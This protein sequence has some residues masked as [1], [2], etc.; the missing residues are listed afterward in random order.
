MSMRNPVSPHLELDGAGNMV[1]CTIKTEEKTDSCHESPQG[2]P[3]SSDPHSSDLHGVP[4]S[5]RESADPRTLPQESRSPVSNA[6]DSRRSA[7]EPAVS[8]QEKLDFNRNLKE[9]MPT[10]EKL[11][12]SDWKERLLGRNTME[13]KEVKG[14][15]ESLAEKELQLLVMIN[16]L[17]TLRDQLLTAHSEQKNMAAMLFEKQQQQMELA[18]QQ[19]EQASVRGTPPVAPRRRAQA[20]GP[21]KARLAGIFQPPYHCCFP[22]RQIAKQ[23]QQ[24]IQQQ[25]K[26]NLLQQQIQQV[27]MPYVMIPAFPPSH[28]PLPVTSDSQLALPIQPI[29]CKPVEY[30][31]QLLH[32]PPP[33]TLKRPA[34]SGHLQMQESS[35]PLNLTAKPK[36]SELSS[37]SSSPS[38]K[39]SS[40][41]S[42]TP[43]HGVTRDLQSSPPSLPLGFLGEGD[44]ITKALQD[45]RQLLHCHSGATESSLNNPYRKDQM[46]LDSSPMKERMEETCM[47]RLDESMLTCDVDGSR[48]FP[49]SRNNNHIKRPMNA[50]MV[51]AKD[52]RRKI[53]QAFPDMHNSSISK[54]LGSRWKS[55][56]NQEKQPYYEEQARLSRQHLEKYPDY[57]YKPRPKRTCIVEGKRLRVG[58]YKALMR[59][60]RQDTRQGYLIAPQGSQMQ[61]SSSDVLYQR[62]VS[63]QLAPPLVEHYLPRSMDPNMPVIVNTRSLKSQEGDGGEDGHS[64]ADGEMYRYSEDE[65]SEG[66]DKSDGELVVLTD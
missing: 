33:P 37:A 42:L 12:S 28:Q 18:R 5:L 16:Q 7:F 6:L 38:L 35:Q 59:N 4:L 10:I 27:N 3:T 11:L 24:L 46:G 8:S 62:P 63:M 43:N 1:N 23:Q 29:P 45:A 47:H 17:S 19:Q 13:S 57:K 25:H 40:C 44:A 66:E 26:I 39:M 48:H 30:P 51:W 31:M 9:V 56:T 53:L 15:Q 22:P 50:F 34:G 64:V 41:R 58:E 60:R 54:I 20:N 55:M 61:A 49:E 32:S 36:S 21:W 2:G 52:E 65:D 14:T